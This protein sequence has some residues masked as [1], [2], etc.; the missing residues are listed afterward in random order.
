MAFFRKIGGRKRVRKETASTPALRGLRSLRNATGGGTG[1]QPKRCRKES[2]GTVR[3]WEFLDAGVRLATSIEEEEIP[4]WIWI[5]PPRPARTSS[6]LCGWNGQSSEAR[7]S[8]LEGM[9]QYHAQPQWRA[10]TTIY[11][12][13]RKIT[14]SGVASGEEIAGSEEHGIS[15]RRACC[16]LLCSRKMS[17]L[18]RF[19][20][21]H[22]SRRTKRGLRSTL[23]L[24]LAA[25]CGENGSS[26]GCCFRSS[27]D[28]AA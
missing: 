18:A 16:I 4:P 22:R 11:A 6:A 20:M 2:Y 25:V 9:L 14:A 8:P 21:S 26:K 23:F 28:S 5:L 17:D 24:L 13:R 7:A 3:C 27:A 15:H 10:D 1:E 12:L 19:I